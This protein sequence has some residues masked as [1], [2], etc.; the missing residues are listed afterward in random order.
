MLRSSCTTL[1]LLAAVV[2]PAVRAADPPL[3]TAAIESI[4]GIKGTMNNAE[5]V[6]KCWRRPKIDPPVR[7]VPTEI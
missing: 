7:V 4:T 1:A 3:D 2:A 5:N 6:F